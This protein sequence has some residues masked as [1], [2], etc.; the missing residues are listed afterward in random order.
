MGT[1]F[2]V[3]EKLWI[4]PKI[5]G[6]PIKSLKLQNNLNIIILSSKLK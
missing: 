3:V 4:T 5:K 6:I 1:S 2:E